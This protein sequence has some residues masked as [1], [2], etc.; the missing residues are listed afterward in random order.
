MQFKTL[1]LATQAECDTIT[2][3]ADLTRASSVVALDTDSGPIL[4]VIRHYT[5]LDP[6]LFPEGCSDQKKYLFLWGVVGTLRTV[7]L[8]PEIYFNVPVDD[9]RWKAILEKGGAE[10]TSNTPEFRYKLRL[11]DVEQKENSNQPKPAI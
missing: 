9:E 5:E 7:N 2:D 8:I 1:R 6:V 11:Q 10:S 4:G 3:R